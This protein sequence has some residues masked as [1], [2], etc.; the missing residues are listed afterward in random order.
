LHSALLETS[1]P[2]EVPKGHDDPVGGDALGEPEG[3]RS[4]AGPDLEAARSGT[5][6]QARQV[7]A[8]PGVER[9][10]ESGEPNPL[11]LPRVVVL[12]TGRHRPRVRSDPRK[13]PQTHLP[14]STSPNTEG[15]PSNSAQSGRVSWT[16][17]RCCNV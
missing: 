12:V 11:H 1:T 10:L 4:P 13:A 5:G 7:V 6:A 2:E 15:A 16:T 17:R 8:G 9:R 14:T 3:H